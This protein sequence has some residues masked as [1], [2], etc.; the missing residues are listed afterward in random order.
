[1]K[2]FSLRLA[3]AALFSL[4]TNSLTQAAFITPSE[5][6][7]PS[8]D[9]TAANELTTYQSWDVFTSV[10]GPNNPDVAEINPSGVAN[11]F[12]SAAP[13]SGAF[14]TG[15]GNIYSFSG[16]I[17]PSA[18][19]PGYAESSHKTRFLLQVES[20]GNFIDLDDVLLDG[21]PVNTLED[22]AYTE[23]SNTPLGGF[24]GAMIEHA[25]EFTAPADLASY[26]LDFGWSAESASL[27]RLSVDTQ[28]IPI[29]EP[30]TLALGVGG[31][32]CLAGMIFRA[33]RKRQAIA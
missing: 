23:L 31:I 11:A 32:G 2:L 24:G 28:A 18:I 14:L 6:T 20:N 3:L 19:V 5:W 22:F 25:W 17:E 16:V 12:D 13:G 27:G 4:A 9:T 8:D 29:P 10:A 7:R 21:V 1:M 33:R 15:G 30:G 26:Q